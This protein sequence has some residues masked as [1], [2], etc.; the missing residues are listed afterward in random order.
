[1][2]GSL[3]RSFGVDSVARANHPGLATTDM[4]RGLDG[5]IPVP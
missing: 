3:D 5:T 2:D 1:M 4:V